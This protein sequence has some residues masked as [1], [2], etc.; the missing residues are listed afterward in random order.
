MRVF[1]QN[2]GKGLLVSLMVMLL[3]CTAF[4]SCK[5]DDDEGGGSSNSVTV[6]DTSTVTNKDGS[7]TTTE[8]MSDGSTVTTTVK[9]D[10]NGKVIETVKVTETANGTVTTETTD[11]NG[12]TETKTD[13]KNYSTY[14]EEGIVAVE[15][16]NFDLAITKFNQA[17]KLEAND[18]TRVYSALA[19]LASISTKQATA[20]F[21]KK[22][23]GI[24]NYPA[25][26]N[27][28]FSP[29]WL[30]ATEYIKHEDKDYIYGYKDFTKSTSSYARYYKANITPAA[31]YS[32]NTVSCWNVYKKATIEGKT[33][34]PSLD[35]LARYEE[36]INGSSSYSRYYTYTLDENGE[37]YV[38]I[39]SSDESLASHQAY[40][41]EEYDGVDYTYYKKAMFPTLSVPDWFK[42]SPFSNYFGELL[43]A[44]ILDGNSNGLNDALDDL[45]NVLFSSEYEDACKK[46][47][48]VTGS[49]KIPS[50]VIDDFGLTGIVGTSDV[51]L[52]KAELA[53][54]KTSFNILKATVEYAQSYNLNTDLSFLKFN[55]ADKN[56]AMKVFEKYLQYDASIDPLANGFM[57][58]RS[59]EKMAASK[60][61]FASAVSDLIAAYDDILKNTTDYPTALTDVLNEYKVLREGAVQLK[62][63]ITDGG[64]F[65]IPETDGLP[66]SWPASGSLYIDLG[67][68]FDAS[69]FA[70][71]NFIACDEN[72]IPRIRNVYSKY[73]YD[74]NTDEEYFTV[75]EAKKYVYYDNN[76]AEVEVSLPD[77][78]LSAADSTGKKTVD[79]LID[80]YKNA[81]FFD[82]DDEGYTLALKIEWHNLEKIFAGFDFASFMNDCGIEMREHSASSSNAGYHFTHVPVGVLPGL[83]VYNFYHNGEIAD[84]IKALIASK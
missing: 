83:Y 55:W 54:I 6:T 70:L 16:L 44:N 62:A 56:A 26:M 79:Y 29:D 60:E 23:L 38:C 77:S 47:D 20:D 1:K 36:D 53:L 84:D 64:K 10:E 61:H 59:P 76:G 43:L 21:V 3:T 65:Y 82:D 42:N 5:N 74:S 52:G 48:A 39:Y 2:F 32:S 34:Y 13:T 19:S 80:A 9:K 67:K 33:F 81:K 4:V 66:A 69:N 25:T 71:K 37:Y 12:K 46:I 75:S 73:I 50:R 31:E 30:E 40:D 24:T 72:N 17:Y 8:I 7:V 22:Y 15:N 45:Y 58:Q 14:I 68:L 28:L 63:A 49:V 41:Y 51:K 11:A 57:S 78:Q 35:A 27:A 18:E